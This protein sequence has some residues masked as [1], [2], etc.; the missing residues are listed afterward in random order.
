MFFNTFEYDVERFEIE[1]ESNPP[2]YFCETCADIYLNLSHLG[3]CIE[4]PSNMK[5]LLE[6]YQET[7]GFK[8]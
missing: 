8:K 1:S 6:E 4:F 2:F 3:Y 5:F 7:T